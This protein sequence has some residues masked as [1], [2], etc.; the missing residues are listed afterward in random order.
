MAKPTTTT[1]K[2]PGVVEKILDKKPKTKKTTRK[3]NAPRVLV[4]PPAPKKKPK[5]KKTETSFDR[6][7]RLRKE[8]EA[9]AKGERRAAGLEAGA[10]L[11]AIFGDRLAD[12][13]GV[14]DPDDTISG[15]IIG[16]PEDQVDVGHVLAAVRDWIEEGIDPRRVPTSDLISYRLARLTVQDH[17]PNLARINGRA[18]ESRAVQEARDV[19]NRYAH[20]L[21]A[22]R[23]K[24]YSNGKKKTAKK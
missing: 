12:L 3:A 14:I 20:R 22:F 11:I 6:R 16:S 10:K 8:A 18:R 9:K 4:A 23:T 24:A 7:E 5:P 15:A 21:D 17:A 1:A 13:Y 2:K 19:V